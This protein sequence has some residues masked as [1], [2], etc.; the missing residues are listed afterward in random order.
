M[1]FTKYN[2]KDLIG[3]EVLISSRYHKQIK[4]INKVLKISFCVDGSATKFR[5]ING[6]E[7]GGDTWSSSRAE[8]ITEK[9]AELLRAKWKMESEMYQW[10]TDIEE[11]LNK[12]THSQLKQIF[13]ILK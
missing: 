13:E 9:D 5:L 7:V 2:P 11:K 4:K 1:D 3:K 10:K 8:L 6:R 12:A